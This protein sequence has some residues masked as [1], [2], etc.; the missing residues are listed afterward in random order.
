MI[1]GE[2]SADETVKHPRLSSDTEE[3][4]A[5]SENESQEVAE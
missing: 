3:T 5:Y 1:P 4:D 2:E